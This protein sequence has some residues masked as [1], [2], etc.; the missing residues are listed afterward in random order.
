MACAGN[1]RSK[2]NC[3][4]V[5]RELRSDKNPDK[6]YILVYMGRVVVRD[7]VK[8]DLTNGCVII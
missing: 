8:V 2:I 1:T 7:D 5:E 3:V 4:V 6:T